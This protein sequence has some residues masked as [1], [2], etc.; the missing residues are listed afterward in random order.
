MNFNYS[1]HQSGSGNLEPEQSVARFR[2]HGSILILPVL[3]LFAA[4]IIGGGLLGSFLDPLLNIL[5]A[6]VA[7]FLF[8][9]VFLSPYLRW[10]ARQ[11]TVTTHRV[12]IREGVF[13]RKK[14]DLPFS[15][16]RTI[17]TSRSLLQRINGSGDVFIT[18]TGVTDPVVL[19]SVPGVRDV[20]ELL[21]QLVSSNYAD[22][23]RHGQGFFGLGGL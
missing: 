8:L 6:G 5:T 20:A 23:A 18:L 10:L 12:I 16:V 15:Q 13:T 19:K 17:S 3:A 11:V 4:A 22:Q 2:R 14:H 1:P 9:V 21:Q 7:T